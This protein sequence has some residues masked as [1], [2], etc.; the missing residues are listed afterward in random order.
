MQEHS[1][2]I[3]INAPLVEIWDM[4]WYRKPDKPQHALGSITILHPGDE[5]GEGLV[6]TCKFP[7]PKFLMSKGVGTSWEWVTNVKLHE[8]WHYDAIGKPLWSRAAGS[9]R[10]EALDDDHTRVHFWESYE[11][12]NPWMR[13]IGLEKYV[14]DRL[15]ADNDTVFAALDRNLKWHRDRRAREAAETAAGSTPATPEPADNPTA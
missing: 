1:Y 14:H 4:F 2:S 3:D 15:S 7:V 10:L 12:F 11:A 9:V 5:I 13:R 8:S 6:R